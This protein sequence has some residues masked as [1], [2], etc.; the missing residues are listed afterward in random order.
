MTAVQGGTATAQPANGNGRV[1]AWRLPRQKTRPR[2]VVVGTRRS[3][4]SAIEQRLAKGAVV[5][6]IARGDDLIE[7]LTAADAVVVVQTAR[8]W[9]LL[10]RYARTLRAV[11]SGHTLAFGGSPA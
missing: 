11:G 7:A 2:V 3:L 8:P 10:S 1:S 5:D 9:G 4:R 6:P